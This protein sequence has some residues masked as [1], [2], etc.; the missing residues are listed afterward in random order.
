MFR[1][2]DELKVYVHR[3]AVDFRKS[4]NGL[5]AI[6]EQSMEL[7]PFAQAVYVF[8]NQ[9]RDRSKMLLW[10]RNGFWLLM[11]RLEQD[12]FVW[13]RKE[14]VLKLGIEQLH[15]LLEGI[16]IEAMRAHPTRYYQRVT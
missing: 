2:G 6:V 10:D 15:W 7:D 16:D 14:A 9:R 5:A 11:K 3:D 13:P 12:R 8:S 1:L 4:I